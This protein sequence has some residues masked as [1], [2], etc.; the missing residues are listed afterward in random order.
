M[1]LT[2]QEIDALDAQAAGIVTSLIAAQAELRRRDPDERGRSRYAQLPPT[3]SMVPS[4]HMPPNNLGGRMSH[5]ADGWPE[6][7]ARGAVVP[8]MV[9][10]AFSVSEYLSPE[11][12][13][14]QWGH[15]VD[16]RPGWFLVARAS[17]GAEIY[18]RVF[19]GEG[20]E[21]FGTAVWALE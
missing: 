21:R 5:R 6:A 1:A 19:D 8:A 2:R 7:I 10:G 20:P 4:G 16:Y 9:R 3:S 13:E 12:R 11:R 14:E 17:D 18:R 15:V